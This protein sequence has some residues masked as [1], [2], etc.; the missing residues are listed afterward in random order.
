MRV[1]GNELHMY[2]RCNMQTNGKEQ[3]SARI[4]VQNHHQQQQGQRWIGK[5]THVPIA[6]FFSLSVSHRSR[7]GLSEGLG[8]PPLPSVVVVASFP[9]ISGYTFSSTLIFFSGLSLSLPCVNDASCVNDALVSFHAVGM[10][11]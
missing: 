2:S 11:S 9:D 5:L 3:S 10:V 8:P 1:L 7:A 6:L 4:G